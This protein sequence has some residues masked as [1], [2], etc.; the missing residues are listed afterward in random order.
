VHCEDLLIND[1]CNGQAVEAVGE[2]LP[3]LD[4]VSSLALIVESVDTVDGRAFMV[5]A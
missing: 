1:S 2:G 3:E 4:I 5:A